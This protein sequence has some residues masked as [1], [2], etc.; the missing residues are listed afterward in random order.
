MPGK[1]SHVPEEQ[2]L[3]KN[4][5]MGVREQPVKKQQVSS[6]KQQHA[7]R[8]SARSCSELVH[9]TLLGE[10]TCC[11]QVRSRNL[12]PFAEGTTQPDN[13]IQESKRLSMFC[14]QLKRARECTNFMNNCLLVFFSLA[15]S[16]PTLFLRFPS[17][18]SF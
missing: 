17:F 16:I 2:G 9:I 14:P 1:K 8:H 7:V 12:Q 4:P 13:S 10:Q 18:Q 3:G 11:R 15:F 5:P 6:S